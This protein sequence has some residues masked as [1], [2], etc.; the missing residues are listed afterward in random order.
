MEIGPGG[1]P[2]GGGKKR[3]HSSSS[4][5]HGASIGLDADG[6]RERRESA[7]CKCVWAASVHIDVQ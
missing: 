5:G 6:V 7:W 2:S 4:I 1:A 3:S